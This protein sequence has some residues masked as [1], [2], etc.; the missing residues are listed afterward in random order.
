[1]KKKVDIP[2]F[3]FWINNSNGRD[4]DCEYEFA[5]R[6]SCEECICNGGKFD[7]RKP[8]EKQKVKK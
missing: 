5:G 7:P 1:M 2:C 6:I 3:G 8:R 4:F